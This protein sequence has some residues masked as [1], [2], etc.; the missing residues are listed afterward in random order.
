MGQAVG[1]GPHLLP[2][3]ER[4]LV[5]ARRR[6]RPGGGGPVGEHRV[7]VAATVGVVQDPGPVRGLL[8]EERGEDGPVELDPP[9][10]GQ[11]LLDGL[12]GQLVPEG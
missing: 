7:D 4:L 11:A 1:D 10:A 6:G 8:V 3:G 2:E 5:R 12:A 9:P